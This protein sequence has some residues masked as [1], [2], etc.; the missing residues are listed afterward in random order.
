[1]N[2]VE[3]DAPQE[4]QRLTLIERV[5]CLECGFVYGK[6]G[7]G[8]VVDSNPGCPVCGYVGW[9]RADVEVMQNA[10]QRRFVADHRRQR[11]A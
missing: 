2:G 9:A 4:R 6:P 8:R 5:R 3:E 11:S 10:F 7:T 1:L